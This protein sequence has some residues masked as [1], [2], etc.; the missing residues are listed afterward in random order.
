MV[1]SRSLFVQIYIGEA[2][3]IPPPPLQRVG[4]GSSVAA[5]APQHSLLSQYREQTAVA[6]S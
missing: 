1:L 3:K 5:F 6:L 2:L 4:R